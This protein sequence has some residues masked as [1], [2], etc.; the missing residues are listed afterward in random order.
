M[1]KIMITIDKYLKDPT[2]T[3]HCTY[4]QYKT[5]AAKKNE[6][7]VSTAKFHKEDYSEFN[8][9]VIVRMKHDLVTLNSDKLPHHLLF[10]TFSSKEQFE[11]VFLEDDF[12]E[13]N[14]KIFGMDDE[15][16]DTIHRIIS[17]KG[18]IPQLCFM[19]YTSKHAKKSSKKRKHHP[20]GICFATI[21]S[22]IKE[23]TIEKIGLIDE[24]A[25]RGYEKFIVQEILMRFAN[26]DAD[27]VTIR[28]FENEALFNEELY[29]SCGFTEAYRWHILRRK[30]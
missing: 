1:V 17:D 30:L 16:F 24:Y 5:K 25:K 12:Y 14:R 18:Y 3:L 6:T 28:F 7:I 29:T 20:I 22:S 11:G 13:M 21:D 9:E 26:L 10:K 19:L 4:N 23:A 8:D 2:R 15:E 27:F